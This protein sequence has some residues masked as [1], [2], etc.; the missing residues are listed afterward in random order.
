MFCFKR[1]E[2]DYPAN[3]SNKHIRLN[4]GMPNRECT[5]EIQ[6]EAQSCDVN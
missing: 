5:Q 2:T 3:Q 4:V 1:V 6:H